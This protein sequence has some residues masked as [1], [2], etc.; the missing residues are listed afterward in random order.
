MAAWDSGPR[1]AFASAILWGAWSALV[2][3]APAPTEDAPW[4][5]DD[6]AVIA[7]KRNP[8]GAHVFETVCA[9]CHE[10]GVNRAPAVFL[11]TGM[12]PKSIYRVL[13][14]GAMQVQA[15]DLS[16]GDKLAVADYLGG[17]NSAHE[18]N[19][20]APICTGAALEF[21]RQQPPSLSLWGL[22]LDNRR[23][24][25]GV[26]AGIGRKNVASLKLKWA[27]G[28]EAATRARSQAAFAGGAIYV[29]GQD[30][31]VTAFDAATG[32]SRW[33]FQAIAEVRTSIVV[34]SWKVGD[35]DAHPM[36]YFGDFLGNVY[37]LDAFKGTLIWQD[38]T[39]THPATT[40]TATP[41]LYDGRLYVPVSTLEKAVVSSR[42]DC[43]TA[44]GSIIAY[45]AATGTR[46]WQ[47]YLTDTPTLLTTSSTGIRRYSP[48]GVS[49]WNTPAID[50][51]RGTLYFGTSNN[52]SSPATILSDSVIAMD[53]K[54][55]KIKWSYQA[56]GQDAWNV[57]CG[58]VDH[59]NC[60]KENGPDFDFAAAAILAHASDGREYVLE[61]QKSGW[62]YALQP[63]TGKLIWKTKV[64][65]GGILAGVYFGMA[66]HGD[67]VFV[68]I[69]DAPD[70]RTYQEEARP[71]VYALDLRTGKNIWSAPIDSRV[72]E[73]RG[74]LCAPGIAAAITVTDDLVMTG[75]G[76]GLLRFY[77]ADTGRLVWSYDTTPSIAT[78]GGGMAAGGSMGG[79]AGPVAYHGT[80][81]VQSGYGFAGR[82][83]GNLMLVFGTD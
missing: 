34:S 72:C 42:Y 74:E 3:A 22:T 35:A 46:L 17:A 82:M 49:V 63:D 70:G 29:G 23:Y 60:P 26:T 4:V 20:T 76:D 56:T 28:F 12:L 10:H 1:F 16:D 78:V 6:P 2:S 31:S 15:R 64:G 41:T 19:L 24:V 59:G 65:R 37:A 69:N 54:T 40:L 13:T 62:V 11:L 44:R 27:Y 67:R 8:Q 25:D 38:H 61:G 45:Q 14:Q 73:S 30:G 53:A 71:G 7:A 32:C 5:K 43:C 52:Y 18:A 51:K 50:V 75:A 33:Q 77:D 9:A 36:V 48:S 80:L 79:G 47:R 58:M 55:G 39:D 83:P 57:A 81:V 68:P 21:D 66:V